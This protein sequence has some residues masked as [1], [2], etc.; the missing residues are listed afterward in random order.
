LRASVGA[1][2]RKKAG[3]T[4]D[5]IVT[6]ISASGTVVVDAKGSALFRLE[7]NGWTSIRVVQKGKTI[8]GAGTRLLAA[9][10]KNLFAIDKSQPTKLAEAPQPIL[11]VAGTVGGSVVVATA[12]GLFGLQ[13]TTF[14]PIKNAPRN[15]T[16]LSDR[17][18]RVSNGI[19]D[20]KTQKTLTWPAGLKVTDTTLVGLDTLV[21]VGSRGKAFELVIV[22]ASGAGAGP[23]KVGGAKKAGGA[24]ASATDGADTETIPL[25]NAS[26]VVGLVA[27]KS[28]R[29]VVATRDGHI[30]VR[31]GGTW[32]V[33]E[34]REE[35][36]APKPGPAPAESP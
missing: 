20:L 18:L 13:G 35:L 6:A 11:A 24:G 19:F 3:G 34:V 23:K 17:F 4:A 22:K 8:L 10:G 36:P 29:V 28:G 14:K 21:A 31:D 7:D 16:L 27:D 25:P 32:T 15:A 1:W 26:A 33:T 9:A 5:E 2:I 12:K 30:A